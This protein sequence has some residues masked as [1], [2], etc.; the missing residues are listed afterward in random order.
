MMDEW[1]KL[2]RWFKITIHCIEFIT[3]AVTVMYCAA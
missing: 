1:N 2:P 3:L